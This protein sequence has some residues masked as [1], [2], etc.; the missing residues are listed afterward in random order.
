[1]SI[2]VAVETSTSLSIIFSLA[3][4]KLYFKLFS[5]EHFIFH[6]GI[7]N[8]LRFNC[9]HSIFH[10][11][12]L[13]ESISVGTVCFS[14]DN[15]F[16]NFAK[17][18]KLIPQ[19]CGDFFLRNLNLRILYLAINVCDKE[20]FILSDWLLWSSSRRTT[21][22]PTISTTIIAISAWCS[23]PRTRVFVAI[24]TVR[25]WPSFSFAGPSW[26]LTSAPTFAGGHLIIIKW[27]QYFLI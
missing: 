7:K 13:N 3:S 15:K 18:L 20:F 19:I 22:T 11:F 16:N 25:S 26:A 23:T 6:S 4:S 1:M 17:R 24:G 9:F 27:C 10:I 21:A 5:F 8:M 12:I 14:F 2:F